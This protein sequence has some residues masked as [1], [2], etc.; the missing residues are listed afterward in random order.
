MLKSLIVVLAMAGGIAILAGSLPSLG[1]E[2]A[3]QDK[4]QAAGS[5]NNEDCAVCHE[6]LTKAFDKTPHAVLEKSPKYQLKNSCETCHGPGEDHATSDGDKA[7]IIGFN[8]KSAKVYTSQCL[9]C[10]NKDRELVGFNNHA[11]HAKSGLSCAD[12]HKVHGAAPMTRLL[13]ESANSL[14]LNCHIERRAD[15]AKPFHHRVPENAMRCVDCHQPHGGLERRQLRASHAGEQA[16]AK[17]HTDKAGPFVFE[18]AAHRIRD[19][20][21]CHEP[22]GSNYSKMLVRSTVRSL[23]LE[24]HSTSRN[25]LGSQTPSFHDVRSPRYQNCTTCHMRIHGSNSSRLFLR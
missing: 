4:P 11:A 13:K 23:C 21:S 19:C 17:C 24:C 7:K 3:K 6:D 1:A 25:I 8:G 16:C 15:F 10:H 5:I 9:S 18:H 2:N 12:C 20:Q 22:H 14:C